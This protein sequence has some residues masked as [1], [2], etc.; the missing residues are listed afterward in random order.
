M[1]K[2]KWVLF[3]VIAT[4]SL[5]F[6]GCGEGDSVDTFM[7]DDEEE[8]NIDGNNEYVSEGEN[9]IEEEDNISDEDYEQDDVKLTE[10]DFHT[11]T[12]DEINEIK[13]NESGQI[14]VVM[15][16][17]FVDEFT[18]RPGYNGE[19]TTT[20]D[21]FEKLLET[22]YENDYRLIS[23]RDF[24]DGYITVSAGKI[25][26]VFT[27]DDATSGQFNLIKENGEYISN[28]RSAVGIME[29]FNE[30]HPDFGTKGVFYVN[31]KNPTFEGEGT[32]ED[33]LQYLIDRGFEI[34]NHTKTHINLRSVQDKEVIKREVGGN[35]KLMYSIIPDYKFESFSLPFGAPAGNLL[36]YVVEGEYEGVR[37]KNEAIMEVG[38]RPSFS[39]Y[40]KSL[41]LESVYRVRASG[42]NPVEMD[43][44][45][46]LDNLSRNEQFISDGNPYTVT[47][48][49]ARLGTI[50]KERL[51]DKELITY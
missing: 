10:E 46:W 24:I 51:E 36:N 39:P 25:P 1:H 4:F 16:H 38:W 21:E 26:I 49:E 30:K 5:L 15:F 50:D 40:S 2:I 12:P 27:F 3:L 35:Q 7:P 11:L 8:I 29:R 23:M 31:L 14:M 45:W 44:G 48:P 42:I 19:Y 43:Q 22:L 41:D 37:Y 32:L 17:N 6:V 33:R 20:F 9:K 47:V 34:G 28:P 13:P 18:P